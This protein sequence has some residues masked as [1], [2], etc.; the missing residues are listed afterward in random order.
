MLLQSTNKG[1]A[2]LTAQSWRRAIENASKV[3]G[4]GLDLKY[5]SMATRGDY[6]GRFRRVAIENEV[7]RDVRARGKVN[8]VRLAIEG[9]GAS[10]VVR[11]GWERPAAH[12][13][14]YLRENWPL[15][16]VP[17]DGAKDG[18]TTHW[19]E[20]RSAWQLGCHRWHDANGVELSESLGSKPCGYHLLNF[21]I[22]ATACTQSHG[23]PLSFRVLEEVGMP[24]SLEVLCSV[25][26]REHRVCRIILVRSPDTLRTCNT[27]TMAQLRTF[28]SETNESVRVCKPLR[29]QL[30]GTDLLLR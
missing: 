14:A 30:R 16:F 27:A 22:R 4:R 1:L 15:V 20:H 8:V 2:L 12:G 18:L 29:T 7:R 28:R 6:E 13:T 11:R 26:I 5:I 17:C 9:T 25:S 23:P 21:P 19:T 24:H 3:R 10:G